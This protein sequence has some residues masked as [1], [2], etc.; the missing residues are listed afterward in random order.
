[1]IIRFG[2]QCDRCLIKHQNYSMEDIVPCRYCAR[3]LCDAC[4]KATDH[5]TGDDADGR[6]YRDC[7]LDPEDQ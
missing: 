3:D 4:A 2:A 5:A 7:D 1:M 6:R